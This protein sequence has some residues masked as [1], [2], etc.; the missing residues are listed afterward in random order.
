MQTK[1]VVNETTL[2]AKRFDNADDLGGKQFKEIGVS[3]ANL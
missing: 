2:D 3:K 1:T